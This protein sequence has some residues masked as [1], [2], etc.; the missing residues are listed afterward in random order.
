MR[1]FVAARL[2]SLVLAGCAG[3]SVSRPPAASPLAARGLRADALTAYNSKEWGRCAELFQRASTLD[4]DAAAD[5]GYAAACCLSLGG[6]PAGAL[7]ELERA[8]AA[9]LRDVSHVEQDQDLASLHADPRWP[10]L[11]ARL[12][13]NADAY[14]AGASAELRRIHE[15][16][17]GDRRPGPAGIDWTVVAPRDAARRQRVKELLEAGEAKVSVDFYH[18]AMVFQHGE[19]V[20]DYRRA[21]ELASKAAELDPGNRRARWLAAASRDRELMKLGKPQLYGT[22][23]R[24]VDGAWELYQT[25]PSVTDEERARWNVPPLAEARARVIEMNEPRP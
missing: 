1:A 18:A 9:G 7:A 2:V 4:P 8:A 5:D 13:A 25:D 11:L 23:F 10:T 22:Q 17:Q 21:H 24:K 14:Y 20:A 15:E 19:D 12:R 6:D 3:S 16:D